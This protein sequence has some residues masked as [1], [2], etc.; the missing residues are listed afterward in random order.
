MPRG[1]LADLVEGA[2]DHAGVG[3][4]ELNEADLAR[5]SPGRRPRRGPGPDTRPRPADNQSM[6]VKRGEGVVD[7]RRQG[8]DGDLDQLVDGE[9]RILHQRPVRAGDVRLRQSAR[10]TSGAAS[11]GHTMARG[12]PVAR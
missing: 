9:D 11:R 1:A 10:A 4:V 6:Q 8:P 12:R 7:R 2:V 3:R 5:T